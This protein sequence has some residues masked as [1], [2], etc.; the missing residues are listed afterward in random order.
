MHYFLD[1]PCFIHSPTL[2]TFS[3]TTII[4][5]NYYL[6]DKIIDEYINIKIKGAYKRYERSIEEE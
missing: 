1:I 6:K 4:T 5:P 2:S 3:K